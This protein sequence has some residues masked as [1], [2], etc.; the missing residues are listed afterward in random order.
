MASTT[1][2]SVIDEE[3]DEGGGGGSGTSAGETGAGAVA[4]G[5]ARG[6]LTVKSNDDLMCGGTSKSRA[7]MQ[8]KLMRVNFVFNPNVTMGGVQFRC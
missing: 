4:A 1:E 6:L 3:D 2:F 7:M 8:A 5:E